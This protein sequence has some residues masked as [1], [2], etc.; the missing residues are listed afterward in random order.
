[1]LRK[2]RDEAGAWNTEAE[3]RNSRWARPVQPQDTDPSGERAQTEPTQGR[4][5]ADLRGNC[6]K[7][8]EQQK[9]VMWGTRVSA[10][11]SRPRV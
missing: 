1:M 4:G 8:W 5:L 9:P 11:H 7:D 6:W 10:P 3:S 2:I